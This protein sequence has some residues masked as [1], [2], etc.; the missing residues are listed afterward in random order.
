MRNDKGVKYVYKVKCKILWQLYTAKGR[1]VDGVEDFDSEEELNVLGEEDAMRVIGKA[2]AIAL[3]K[4]EPFDD[5][6]TN[7]VP[8]GRKYKPCDI[9]LIS[10]ERGDSVYV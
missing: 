6:D 8:T 9:M 5:T 3:K 1:P 7:D 2:K 4:T 10:I